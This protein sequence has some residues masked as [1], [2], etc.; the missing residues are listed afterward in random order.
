MMGFISCS[1]YFNISSFQHCFSPVLQP[2]SWFYYELFFQPISSLGQGFYKFK[3]NFIVLPKVF[4]SFS[5][6]SSCWRVFT[7][8][9]QPISLLYH[10]FHQV[11]QPIS[12]VGDGFVLS[13]RILLDHFAIRFHQFLP[14]QFWKEPLRSP[15]FKKCTF[16]A[17]SGGLSFWW[18]CE[19]CFLDFLLFSHNQ[20]FSAIVGNS[21]P[22]R[23][24]TFLGLN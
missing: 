13:C 9:S 20:L 5:T 24:R 12:S 21:H 15:L 10:G 8:V 23:Q 18:I 16:G 17:G 2:L 6:I 11:R 4:I 19:Q 3:T 7:S 22:K 14:M 1:T